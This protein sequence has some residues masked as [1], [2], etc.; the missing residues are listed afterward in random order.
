MTDHLPPTDA[1]NDPDPWDAIARFLAGESTPAEAAEVRRWLAEHPGDA[2]VVASLDRLLPPL[3]FTGALSTDSAAPA[4]DVDAALRRVHARIDQPEATVTP[5]RPREPRV[6]RTAPLRAAAA[7]PSAARRWWRSGSLAAAAAI[8]GFVGLTSWNRSHAPVATVAVT[9]DTKVGARDSV[10]LPDSSRVVLAPGSRLVVAANYGVDR[11]DVELVGAGQFTVRH[12][13]KHPFTVRAG[14]AIIRDIGT[15]FAVKASAGADVTVAVTEG[16]VALS[17]SNAS[18][19][20]STVELKAGDRGRLRA[21]G[22]ILAEAGVVTSDEV[23]WVHG[24]LR[25]VDAPLAEVEA[26]LARWYG[27][28]LVVRD[29]EWLSRKLNT[30]GSET[31]G[32]DK[33]IERI[34]AV[35]GGVVTQRGD[36]AFVDKP[37]A[38]SKH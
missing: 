5:L 36:T 2:A 31:E 11:R 4:L 21:D 13:P 7:A 28:V 35:L 29:S 1:A 19:K 37:G 38:R 32:K 30:Y 15:V 18:H 9:Y 24:T 22:T 8:I 34:A 33:I 3:A 27:V 25:Y 17:D 20:A 14:S 16:A 23:S 6:V 10:T 12:D 26:D